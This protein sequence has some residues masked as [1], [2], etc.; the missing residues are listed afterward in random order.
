MTKQLISLS[1]AIAFLEKSTNPGD[2]VYRECDNLRNARM[3][4]KKGT[5]ISAKIYTEHT[6]I[7]IIEAHELEWKESRFTT[8]LPTDNWYIVRA[9]RFKKG[10]IV[11]HTS[12][13]QL[14]FF[15]SVGRENPGMV[16]I[17][18]DYKT[19]CY[20][21]VRIEHLL[22]VAEYNEKYLGGGEG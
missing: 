18:Y 9:P 5:D 19:N 21:F 12:K 6:E 7:E 3:L 2:R 22:S 17:V 11:F 15:E 8:E 20:E 10:E 4:Y 14:V 16:K 13:R 1:G